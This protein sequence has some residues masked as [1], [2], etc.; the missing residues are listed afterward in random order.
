MRRLLRQRYETMRLIGTGAW[1]WRF[2]ERTKNE[3]RPSRLINHHSNEGFLKQGHEAIL[4]I[5]TR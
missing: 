1:A 5:N 3:A 4:L 2:I